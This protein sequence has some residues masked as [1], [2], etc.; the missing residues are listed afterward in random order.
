VVDQSK[1]NDDKNRFL[2]PRA[3]YHGDFKPEN[4]AFN[5]NLQEFAQRVSY[6]CGLETNGKI[7]TEEAYLEIKRLWQRLKQSKKALIDTPK[8]PPPDLP[9]DD[10]SDDQD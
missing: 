2:Y 9:E 4:L 1:N 3:R 5:A 6:I 10:S 7:T 8:P